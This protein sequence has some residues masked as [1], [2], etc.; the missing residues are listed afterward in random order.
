MMI[1]TLEGKPWKRIIPRIGK[2]VYAHWYTGS[3]LFL[4]VVVSLLFSEVFAEGEL[5]TQ[6]TKASDLITGPVAKGVATGAVVLGG[7]G[8]MY[9]GQMMV[10]LAIIGTLML[11]CVG[12]S[13]IGGGFK[14]W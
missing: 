1:E 13:I 10:G 9:A 8:A 3:A 7:A 11:V 2:W 12:L 14:V 6:V 4:I 5:E